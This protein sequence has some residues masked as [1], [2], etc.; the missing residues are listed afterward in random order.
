VFVDHIHAF[1]HWKLIACLT[2]CNLAI[3]KFEKPPVLV[4]RKA[5]MMAL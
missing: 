2:A 5:P 3:V 1:A 4:D